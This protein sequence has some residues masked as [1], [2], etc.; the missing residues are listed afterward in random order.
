MSKTCEAFY[1]DATK[2]G[3]PIWSN[4]GK[5]I[6]RRDDG[7]R[8]CGVHTSREI[9]V[10]GRRRLVCDDHK[11]EIELLLRHHPQLLAKLHWEHRE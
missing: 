11:R 10:D 2:D 5:T 6:E 9:T 4:D 1:Y 7:W 8:K 3:R